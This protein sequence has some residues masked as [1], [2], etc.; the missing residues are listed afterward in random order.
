MLKIRLSIKQRNTL[1]VKKAYHSPALKIRQFTTLPHKKT[2]ITVI[3]H[4]KIFIT[5][6]PHF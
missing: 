4:N 3:P 1:Y 2:Y 5:N 6:L